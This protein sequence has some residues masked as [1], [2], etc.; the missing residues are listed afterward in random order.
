MF[1][2]KQ[3][4]KQP[5]VYA[6]SARAF[7]NIHEADARNQCILVSGESGAG[8]TET[9]KIL[10]RHLAQIASNE[11]TNIVQKVSLLF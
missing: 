9:V 8:K 1:S 10:I 2:G 11:S 6:I 5:H 3:Q 7:Q 4:P